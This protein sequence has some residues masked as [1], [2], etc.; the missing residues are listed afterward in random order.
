[1]V[2]GKW[3][4]LYMHV[5]WRSRS[6]GVPEIWYRV[7]GERQFTNLYSDVPAE[8]ADRGLPVTDPALQHPERSAREGTA[9]PGLTLEGGFYRANAGQKN[10]YW[11]DGMRRRSHET[12]ILAGFPFSGRRP[13]RPRRVLLKRAH[14]RVGPDEPAVTRSSSSR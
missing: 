3:L 13:Y 14:E 10:E 1:M 12:S 4:D 11:W 5:V 8:G 9:S 6:N 2:Y 7:E